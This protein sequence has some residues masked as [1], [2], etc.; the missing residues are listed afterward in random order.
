[1]PIELGSFDVIISM[2]WLA[3]YHAMIIYDKKI[4]RIPY[5]DEM[6]REEDI[7]KTAFRTRYGHYEFQV[8]PFDLTNAPA[9]FMNLMNQAYDE[10]D[11]E[12]HEVRLGR[13]GKSFVSPVKTKIIFDAK[14]KVIAYACRQLKVYEKNYTT[15]DLELDSECLIGSQKEENFITEDLH[16]MINKLEPHGDETLCLNNQSWILGFGDLRVLIMHESHKSK[17]SIHPG[18]NK[19]YQDLKKLYWLPNMKAKIAT[20]VSKCLTCAKNITMDFVPKF[21][22]TTTGQDTLWII[23]DRLTKSAHFLPMREDDL[24]EKLTRQYLKEVISRHG[25]PVSIIFDRD[26]RFTSHFWRSL[27]KAL[28]TQLDMSTA[29]HPQT[30]GQSERTIQTLEDLLRACVL[31]FKKSWDRHLLLVE[32]SYNNSYHTSIKAAPFKALY[33][34]KCRSPI[35]WAEVGGSQL[36]GLEIIHETTEKIVQIKSRIQAARDRQKIYV[37]TKEWEKGTSKALS[38]SEVMEKMSK[39]HPASV[40]KGPTVEESTPFNDFDQILGE[41]GWSY[42]KFEE[43]EGDWENETEEKSERSKTEEN[44]ASSSEAHDSEDLD[45][46]PKDDDG[47]DDEDEHILQDVHVSMNNFA[48]NPNIKNHLS[49]A[50][51]EVDEHDLDVID[52]NSFGSDL[53]DGIDLERRNQLKEL[54]R[55][56]KAN[57]HGPNKYY[58]YLGQ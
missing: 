37:N 19:M 31:D 6:V 36:T 23:I 25:V 43:V 7:L 56:D 26:G 11:P 40:D 12:K 3:K 44:D 2:D 21:P 24:L 38:I 41:K 18:S 20:Y 10:V 51:V 9:V 22:K 15:Y 35:C 8:M 39:Q 48:F 16:G 42:G 58:F 28:G 55:I 53:N 45:Y 30:D 4:V 49:L 32:F 14:E 47:F 46:D 52:C 57:N 17:Y 27:Y 54:R 34:C 50:I 13:K 33:R 29:Y 1:M 5:G